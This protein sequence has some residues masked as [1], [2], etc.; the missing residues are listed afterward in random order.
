VYR[1]KP[2]LT[3]DADNLTATDTQPQ[4]LP[5]STTSTLVDTQPAHAYDNEEGKRTSES[6]VVMRSKSPAAEVSVSRPHS[7][8]TLSTPQPSILPA[9]V[10]LTVNIVPN[11][12][13]GMRYVNAVDAV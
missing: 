7:H 8:T 12:A 6:A 3:D 13:T 2:R 9:H 1:K 4:P 11:A 5:A 10:P